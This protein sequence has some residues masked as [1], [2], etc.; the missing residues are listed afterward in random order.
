SVSFDDLAD[1]YA[2]QIA[3]L[4][5][6]GV[7]LL[8]PET[9]IDTLNLKACLFAIERFFDLKGYR[10]PVMASM[11]IPGE[12]PRNLSGQ[13]VE[14]FWISVSPYKLLS[15]GVN[16]ALGADKMRPHV[17]ALA[18]VASCRISCHPNAG[19]PNTFGEYD[20]TPEFMARVLREFA[21]N[22]WL[23]VVGGC[24]GTTPEHIRAIA[25]AVAD[26]P[27]RRVPD[28]PR[29]TCYSGMD[30]LRIRPESNFILI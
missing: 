28:L 30:P 13:T 15:V 26:L 23:N 20:E 24:C 4:V 27:P 5:A 18:Q 17:E 8:F 3:G 1:S 25:D 7:D 19:L 6:G 9:G 21:A 11:T 29:W 16:C 12:N 2:E 14:G 22:S 10:L